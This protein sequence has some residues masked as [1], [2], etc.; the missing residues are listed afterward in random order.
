MSYVGKKEEKR[1]LVLVAGFDPAS[2]RFQGGPSTW[3]TLH[4]EKNGGA[5]WIRT[6]GPL[7]RPRLSKPLP[8]AARPTL[9]KKHWYP[10]RDSN[11]QNPVSETG[12]YASS[13]TGAN[14]KL[15]IHFGCALARSPRR[16]RCFAARGA[17]RAAAHITIAAL[18][19]GCDDGVHGHSR[20][21]ARAL[22]RHAAGDALTLFFARRWL[23][24]P[25]RGA[26]CSD[27][28]RNNW[29]APGGAASAVRSPHT[30]RVGL[31]KT[32]RPGKPVGLPG[33]LG[34]PGL[35]CLT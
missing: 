1:K 20:S 10:R 29:A 13:V 26:P 28:L 23:P 15:V 7:V 24:H 30:A 3:L 32:K 9:Q 6:S 14:T 35:R 34:A 18:T 2:S 11:P 17:G 25:V 5:C 22:A 27:L 19:R 21:G 31:K 16:V 12:T 8:W 4:P 33:R